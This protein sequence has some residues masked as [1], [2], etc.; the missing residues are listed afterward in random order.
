LECLPHRA[1]LVLINCLSKKRL[2][3]G[4][5]LITQGETGAAL[6]LVQKGTCSVKVEKD[7]RSYKVACLGEGDVVGEMAVLT[8]E[9]HRIHVDAETDLTVWEL[10]RQQFE[11]IAAQHQDL[12]IFLTELVAQRL[13]SC[14]HTADRTIG[15]YLIKH[16]I[17]K[18]G[19]GIVYR[20]I[21]NSLHLPVAIKMLRHDMAMEPLFLDTFR[22]E[23]KMI[24][25]LSHNNIVRVYDIEELYKTVFIVMEYLEGESLDNLL[26]DNGPL[27][28]P[29]AL[30]FLVQICRGLGYAHRKGIVHRD[31]KPDNIFV[32]P[33]DQIKILDFGLACPPGTEDFNLAGTIFYAPPEQITGGAVDARADIYSLGIST[34]EMITGRRPYPESDPAV[35]MDLHCNQDIPDPAELVSGLPEELNM[36]IL[37]ACQRNPEDRYQSM[38]EGVESLRPLCQR[39][40]IAGAE[41]APRR[42][43]LKTLFL[44][45]P[46]EQQMSLEELVEGFGVRAKE[47]GAIVKTVDFKDL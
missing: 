26:R 11:K 20:G 33:D 2:K 42:H 21:H 45:C 4:E 38:E 44:F 19:W 41:R 3:P 24:A 7:G 10:E 31:I 43:K 14:P 32:L 40:N 6:Y 15:K 12:R 9:P 46:D 22:A 28:V 23:A 16:K 25:Q 47:L 30:D 35:L 29:R 36:F 18:G 1:F 8:G 39:L 17:G 34:Y 5:R 37:K 13:E 27:P